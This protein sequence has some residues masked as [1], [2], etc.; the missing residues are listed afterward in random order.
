MSFN[1]KQMRVLLRQQIIFKNT[2][3]TC[4]S[5]LRFLGIYITENLKWGAYV[6]LLRAKLCK[7]VCRMKTWK[8]TMNPCM[9]RFFFFSNF[10]SCLRYGIMLWGGVN[11]RN[12]IFELQKIL[13]IIS[14]VRN[15][16][17]RR[18]IFNDYSILTLSSSYIL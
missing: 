12:N 11:E 14:G 17:S 6:R 15:H 7:V 10:E 3:I 4:Q 9:I 16:M 5:E 18:Q 1:S 13:Q 2:E 8:E